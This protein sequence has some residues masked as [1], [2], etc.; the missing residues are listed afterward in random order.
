VVIGLWISRIINQSKHRAAVIA[1]LAATRTELAE[2]SRQAG[3]MAERE[4]LARDIHDTLAQGFAS[5]LLLLEAAD[6]EI[7]PASAAARPF[8]RDAGR[9]AADNLAEARAMVAALSPPDLRDASL[10]AALGQL[11]DRIGPELGV[12]PR[13][14]VTGPPRPLAGQRRGRAAARHSGS[15]D[16]RAQ[17]RRRQPGQRRARLPARL[18]GA[19][20]P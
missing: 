18:G 6:T 16:Q 12:E 13:L 3:A 7:G 20:D 1:E 8:L 4:R 11:I 17:A 10:P 15:P 19:A 9:T 14:T 5:V 2:L